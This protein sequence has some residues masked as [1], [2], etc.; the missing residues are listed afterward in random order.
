MESGTCI[1]INYASLG[2]QFS[3]SAKWEII[4]TLLDFSEDEIGQP[5][6]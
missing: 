1:T 2:P 6:V 5:H 4:K 3:P